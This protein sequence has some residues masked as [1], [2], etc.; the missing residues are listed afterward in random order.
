M[1]VKTA[2]VAL[3]AVAASGVIAPAARAH[4]ADRWPPPGGFVHA[5]S[6]DGVNPAQHPDIFGNPAMA[7]SFG[8]VYG[9]DRAWHV[10]PNCSPFRPN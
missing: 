6:L 10:I 9:A 7:R 5:C 2:L 8:F 3:T 1:T 4:T